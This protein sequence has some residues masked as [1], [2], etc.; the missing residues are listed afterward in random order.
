MRWRENL[1]FV[2]DPDDVVDYVLNFRGLLGS[3]TISTVT[4]TDPNSVL[5]LGT[6]TASD[7]TVTIF[8]SG[9]T[10]GRTGRVEITIT[11]ANATPRVFERS[12]FV[13]VR[14]L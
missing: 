1:T 7:N 4:A 2:K 13:Q 12:F 8:V 5:T 10:A 11:T 14:D 6:P 3:D 9:G